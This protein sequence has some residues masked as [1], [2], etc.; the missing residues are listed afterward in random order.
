LS[1][2]KNVGTA[3]PDHVKTSPFVRR[4]GDEL[5]PSRSSFAET[6]QGLESASEPGRLEK[7]HQRSRVWPECSRVRRLGFLVFEARAPETRTRA[8]TRVGLWNFVHERLH[9]VVREEA[10]YYCV[11][12]RLSRRERVAV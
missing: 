11:G 8:V 9:D 10:V 5:S 7:F 12:K 1:F 4:V 6:S 3:S 2:R